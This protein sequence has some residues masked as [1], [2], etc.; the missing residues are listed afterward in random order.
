MQLAPCSV[1]NTCKVL[2]FCVP[3]PG[4]LSDIIYLLSCLLCA[5]G[6]SHTGL[7]TQRE[8]VSVPWV[9]ILLSMVV[10][11]GTMTPISCGDAE[12]NEGATGMAG[13]HGHWNHDTD[14]VSHQGKCIAHLRFS[15][16]FPC[17]P[18]VMRIC[19]MTALSTQG[20]LPKDTG[21]RKRIRV[22]AKAHFSY[23]QANRVSI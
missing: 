23:P 1:R 21:G 10:T 15:L 8:L 6:S 12:D 17:R 20:Q 13:W 11:L 2:V 3:G 22:W 4:E 5:F 9:I 14:L 18:S 16:R 7:L 19:P